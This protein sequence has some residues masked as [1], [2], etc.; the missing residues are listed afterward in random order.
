MRLTPSTP[1]VPNCCCSKGSASY[2]SN[3]SFFDIRVLWCSGLSARTPECQKLKLTGKTSMAECKTLMPISHRRHREDKTVLSCLV[4]VCGVNRIGDKTRQFWLVSTQFPICNCSVSNI[5]RTTENLE[6]GNW[7]ETRQYCCHFCSHRRHGQ[8]KTVLSCPCRRCER[9]IVWTAVK[10][11]TRLGRRRATVLLLC[12]LQA[13]ERNVSRSEVAA[14]DGGVDDVAY[15][16]T[17]AE[18]ISC[19]PVSSLINSTVPAFTAYHRLHT[20]SNYF[21]GER[22]FSCLSHG[23]SARKLLTHCTL[24]VCPSVRARSRRTGDRKAQKWNVIQ[25]HILSFGYR[26]AHVTCYR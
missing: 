11:L 15:H 1:A 5:S 26:R 21:I 3:P 8:D 7:I 23:P 20:S 13:G 10:G 25:I 16:V 19:H 6:I 12:S 2:W 4:R 17:E 18:F 22:S 9:P 24:S 14:A